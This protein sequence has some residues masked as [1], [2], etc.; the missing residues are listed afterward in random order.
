MGHTPEPTIAWPA[1][2][3]AAAGSNTRLLLWCRERP[4]RGSSAWARCRDTLPKRCPPV[5][6]R[7]DGGAESPGWAGSLVDRRAGRAR[8]GAM[9]TTLEQTQTDLPRLLDLV[10]E[11]EEM[12]ISMR[13]TSHPRE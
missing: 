2:C 11:G 12:L 5:N 9:T 6:A 7:Q 13:C 10:S 3:L 4:A 8:V 1:K